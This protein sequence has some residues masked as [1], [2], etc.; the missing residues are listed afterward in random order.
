MVDQYR[1][2]FLEG[3]MYYLNSILFVR[4]MRRFVARFIKRVLMRK[5]HEFKPWNVFMVFNR[6]IGA[7]LVDGSRYYMYAWR[8]EENLQAYSSVC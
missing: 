6:D 4:P 5:Y 2:R 8:C 7:I 1:K 3:L